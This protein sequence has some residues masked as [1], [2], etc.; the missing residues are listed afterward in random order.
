M[1]GMID[2]LPDEVV[3]RI[4]Q[5]A[6][7]VILTQ[8]IDQHPRGERVRFA[9]NPVGQ[10]GTSTTGPRT[11]GRFRNLRRGEIE[12]GGKRWLDLRSQRV[13]VAT[14]HYVS[15]RWSNQAVIHRESHLPA[16]RIELSE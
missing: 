11:L 1:S 16:G 3:R 5:P 2:K 4:D 10:D 8:A 12:N 7:E 13:G 14:N 6:T 15:R 9:G